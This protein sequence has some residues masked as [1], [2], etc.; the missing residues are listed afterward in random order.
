M[1]KREYPASDYHG[2]Y[3]DNKLPDVTTTNG[4]QRYIQDVLNNLG[5]FA[6]RIN[7]QGNYRDGKWHKSGSTNGS[8][9]IHC[10]IKTSGGVLP[11]KIEVKNKDTMSKAQLKYQD[12]MA[13]LGALHSVISVGELDEFWDELN[14]I[15]GL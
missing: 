15:L 5:H 3:Y 4:T 1:W 11:W 13:K 8:P 7:T 10:M 12:K 9:D 2:F 6:E 14:R